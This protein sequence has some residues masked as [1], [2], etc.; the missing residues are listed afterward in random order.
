MDLEKERDGNIER[1]QCKAL[2]GGDG[3]V[4][5]LQNNFNEQ[6]QEEEKRVEDAI[7]DRMSQ[8]KDQRRK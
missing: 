3:D 4:R 8:I 5:E 6:L 7:Q 1:A 2:A